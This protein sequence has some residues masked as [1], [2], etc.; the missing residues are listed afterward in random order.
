MLNLVGLA[1]AVNAKSTPLAAFWDAKSTGEVI[2]QSDLPSTFADKYRQPAVGIR[3]TTL[4]LMLKKMLLDLDVEVREGW[5]LIDIKETDESVTAIFDGGR[6]VTGSFLIG[7]DGIKAASRRSLL[8][9][10]GQAE[11]IPVYTGL[12][13]VSSNRYF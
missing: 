8:R 13:Q 5:E 4:N 12:T 7:C 9:N 3:R 11:D 1:E 10:R 2:G 6:S